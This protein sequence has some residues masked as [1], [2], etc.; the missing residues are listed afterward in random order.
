MG[1]SVGMME[2]Y[3]INY[4]AKCEND[5]ET[6]NFLVGEQYLREQIVEPKGLGLYLKCY[7]FVTTLRNLFNNLV[8]FFLHWLMIA[9]MITSTY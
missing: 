3:S 5:P 6:Q 2:K 1:A 9:L 7:F 4:V 8:A